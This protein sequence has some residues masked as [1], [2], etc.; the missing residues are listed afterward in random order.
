MQAQA[1][2]ANRQT[3]TETHAA[4]QL[5][6]TSRK[7]AAPKQLIG[8]TPVY[9]AHNDEFVGVAAGGQLAL[10]QEAVLE[11][12]V[13]RHVQ[14]LAPAHIQ[15]SHLRS[16]GP[17]VACGQ[18]LVAVKR[19]VVGW[20]ERSGTFLGLASSP[21]AGAPGAGRAPVR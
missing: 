15:A 5:S 2:E 1:A 11:D 10:Q 21:Q 17:V 9:A 7:R 19:A 6:M 16:R 20:A 12:R 3:E 8:R 13:Q 4:A 14:L 18:V